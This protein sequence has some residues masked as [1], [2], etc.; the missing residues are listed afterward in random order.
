MRLLCLSAPSPAEGKREEPA[1]PTP[2]AS[3]GGPYI[4]SD[5]GG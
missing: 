1:T 4:A 2:T 5:M 3:P